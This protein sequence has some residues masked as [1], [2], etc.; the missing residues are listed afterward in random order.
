MELKAG[1]RE[2]GFGLETSKSSTGGEGACHHR[3]DTEGRVAMGPSV[4]ANHRDRRQVEKAHP[5][6]VL[7]EAA[8]ASFL[9][10]PAELGLHSE[11]WGMT[12]QAASRKHVEP[13]NTQVH[14]QLCS[15]IDKWFLV[16]KHLQTGISHP[17]AKGGVRSRT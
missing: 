17:Y 11:N 3:S 4:L 8:G 13:V 14:V 16:S 9:L 12:E 7:Q 2:G 6:S 1:T 15:H 10:H 5:A